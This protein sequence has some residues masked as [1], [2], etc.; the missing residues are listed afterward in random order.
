MLKTLYSKSRLDYS[1]K[2]LHSHFAYD[3]FDLQGDSLVAFSG[4][5]RVEIE[6][7]VD[8]ADVKQNAGI[9]SESMLH[10]IGEFFDHD[11]EKMV[12]RQRLLISI[13]GDILAS[14]SGCSIERRGDDLYEGSRKISVSIATLSPVSSVMHTGINI[15]S[16]NTPVPAK[17]LDDYG[18]DAESFARKV[19]DA[20]AAEMEGVY[21]ARCKVRGVK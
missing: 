2:E 21:M 14:E 20:F 7:L 11:L 17:G 15:S 1:G 3:R 10:F 9:Y 6:S 12:L 5:C 13:I 18:I 16:K 8:L 4:G 19:L